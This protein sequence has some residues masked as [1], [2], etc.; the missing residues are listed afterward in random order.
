MS[1]RIIILS[2]H[3][4]SSAYSCLH[5][6]KKELEKNANVELWSLTPGESLAEE[7]GNGYYSFY[8][9]KYWRIPGLRKYLAKIKVYQRM[10]QNPDD[11]YVIND[12]DFIIPAFYAKKKNKKIKI[13]HYNTEIPGADVDVDNSILRFYKNH[14]NFPDM[15]IECLKER[16]VWRKQTYHIEKEIFVINNTLPLSIIDDKDS[17]D[18]QENIQKLAGNRKILLY[19]GRAG[20]SRN[21]T[22]VLN[23][24]SA[25]E[26]DIFFLFYCYGTEKE[27]EE[28]NAW[29]NRNKQLTNYRIN[30]S[31]PRK[32][33]LQVMKC[34]DIGVNY[35]E[36]HISINHK[37]ASPSKF[38]EYI[39]CGMNVISTKNE[40]ID[41][42][43][44]TNDLGVCLCENE[45]ISDGLRRLLCKGLL[46][47]EDV[48]KL[49]K[50]K[51][52]Y[53]VD[54]KEAISVINDL[55]LNEQQNSQRQ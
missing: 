24:V 36:P 54:S 3:N 17:A 13:I 47:K 19:A 4:I 38:F 46:A 41:K 40:G 9:Q 22:E 27:F 11:I 50:E 45:K 49:F 14:A 48:R 39:A 1:K 18:I 32:D 7:Y 12:L 30:H 5:Y 51:Y 43:I 35:Y 16:A 6:L 37:Y 28:L 33:L 23:C 34:C 20:S 10:I 15:I 31:I 29:T 8:D 52:D 44:E 26:N 53:S 25:F 2:W 42:I 21:L 55:L